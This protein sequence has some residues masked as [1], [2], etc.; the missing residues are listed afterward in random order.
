[1]ELVTSVGR[2]R[3]QWTVTCVACAVSG[4]VAGSKTRGGLC[5]KDM[6]KASTYKIKVALG[7]IRLGKP[8]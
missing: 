2:G 8:L 4:M 6:K 1:L 3:R 7:G 5:A